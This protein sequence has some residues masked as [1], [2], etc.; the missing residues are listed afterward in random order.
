MSTLK[1]PN[2]GAQTGRGLGAF[3]S[4]RANRRR[5]GISEE[6]VERLGIERDE[7]FLR[8]AFDPTYW[9]LVGAVE[10]RTA[11][12]EPLIRDAEPGT[13][14]NSKVMCQHLLKVLDYEPDGNVRFQFTGGTV[15]DEDGTTL[16][17]LDVPE[18]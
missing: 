4:V 1:K 13:V 2:L 18:Q 11:Q 8:I 3:I 15:I 12:K 5:V 6:A 10:E 14:A 7:H 9:P 16:H 17:R